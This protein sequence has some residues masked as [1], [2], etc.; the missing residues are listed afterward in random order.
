MS[1]GNIALVGVCVAAA[2]YIGVILVTSIALFPVGLIGLL[3][4]GFVGFLLWA[5]LRQKLDDK[6]NR[7]YEENVKE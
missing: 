4:I 7:H 5:V 2:V 1:L 3:V 6:E